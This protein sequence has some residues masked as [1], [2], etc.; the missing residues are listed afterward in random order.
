MQETNLTHLDLADLMRWPNLVR[1][2][3]SLNRIK[4]VEGTEKELKLETLDLSY[5][6]IQVKNIQS[7]SL[8]KY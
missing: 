5:N 6:Q 8:K 4:A 3:L 7:I 1:L 2:D